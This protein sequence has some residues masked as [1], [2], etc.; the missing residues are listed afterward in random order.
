MPENP[1]ERKNTMTSINRFAPKV[2]A[3][4]FIVFAMAA[5]ASARATFAQT[6]SRV[7]GVD[8]GSHKAAVGF[9][10]DGRFAVI[11]EKAISNG[12]HI[13]LLC[14]RPLMDEFLWADRL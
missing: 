9:H 13:Y 8:D 3:F 2:R 14:F 11:W 5:L 1:R 6:E 10:G 12:N 4:S 7:D